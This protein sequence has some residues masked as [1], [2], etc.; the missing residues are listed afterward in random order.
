M[1]QWIGILLLALG[2]FACKKQNLPAEPD[3]PP[4]IPLPALPFA[5]GAD[6]S[7]LTEMET[8]GKKFFTQ[9]G[10]EKEC[11]ALLKDMGLNSIRLRVWVNPTHGWNNKQDVLNKA[12]R[13]H[14][15]GLLLMI[16]FH[17]SD[18]WADPGQQ[19]PPA[20]WAGFDALGMQSAIAVHTTD[21]L[22]ALKAEGIQP[23][24]VQVGNE[25]NDG[26][27]WPRGRASLTGGMAHYA[28]MITAGYDAVK[29]IFPTTR[30]VVHLANGDR[31]AELRWNL[32]GLTQFRAKFDAIGLSLYPDPDNWQEKSNTCYTNMQAL[33]VQFKTEI[34]L[35]EVGMPWDSPA[36]CNA[37]LKDIVQKT[38]LLPDNKGTGVLYWEPQSFGQWKGYTRGAFD[39]NG[40]PTI[41]LK[42]LFE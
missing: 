34:M 10:Q 7:W 27:L 9:G 20:A 5:K 33:A 22:T 14:Q 39:D 41:A 38:K 4:A 42:G 25:T 26:M 2:S 35:A 11:M 8:A 30:V 15:L 17:Y 12:K 18:S 13:A 37:F 36:A 19:N 23:Q 1:I 6:V 24:W 31:L 32:E 29:K 40:K 28:Q 21:I 3:S 16:N